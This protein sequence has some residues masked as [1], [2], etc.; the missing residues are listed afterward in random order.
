[1]PTKLDHKG[2]IVTFQKLSALD[3]RPKHADWRDEFNREVFKTTFRD[4]PLGSV[5][6][7]DPEVKKTLPRHMLYFIEN[8]ATCYTIKDINDIIQC[9]ESKETDT[10]PSSSCSYAYRSSLKFKLHTSQVPSMTKKL[11]SESS[12]D[13]SKRVPLQQ[14]YKEM[15]GVNKFICP[16]ENVFD[17]IFWAHS[18]VGHK[19][20]FSTFKALDKKFANI[21]RTT[22]TKFI[23]MCPICAST[24]RS[25][26]GRKK[27][28]GPGIA[29][30]SLSFRDR[31]QVDLINFTSSPA[32][33]HNSVTMKYLMTVKDHFSRFIWLRPLAKKEAG[34]VA[35]ELRHLFHEIGFPLIFHT[36]NGTEFIAKKV[37]DLLRSTVSTKSA[38]SSSL[39]LPKFG[40]FCLSCRGPHK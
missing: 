31:I 40:N 5:S 11:S 34:L 26:I 4:Q 38:S 15:S 16:A 32:V 37:Y 7:R 18:K 3:D 21:T 20:T 22:V 17:E 9:I 12:Q 23:A 25:D 1:M 39:P 6:F 35:A 33:D 14:I 30:K 13:E 2:K 10:L 24:T 27:C 19:K 36:D 29:I 28:D 8:S